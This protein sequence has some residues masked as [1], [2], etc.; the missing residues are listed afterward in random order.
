[1]LPAHDLVV[2]HRNSEATQDLVIPFK[3][4]C[5]TTDEMLLS[6]VKKNATVDKNWLA[7]E[8]ENQLTAILCASGPSLADNVETI[9]QLQKDGGCTVFAMNGASK[10]LNDHGITPF[11]QVIV[12]ARPQTA[13]LVDVKAWKHL[14]AS[15][16]DPKCFELAPDATIWHQEIGQI[17]DAL[18]EYGK[19][20]ALIGGG[21]SVGIS[22]MCI[23][24]T[25][26]YR[27]IK[28]F[29]YDSSHRENESHAFRQAMNDSEPLTTIRSNGKTYLCSFTMKQQAHKF[30][31]VANAL[32]AE[33]CSIDVIGDGLLPSIWNGPKMSE[34][35]K[36]EQMWEI[37]GYR[38]V[39]PGE[40]IAQTF[41]D[42]VKPEP[43][44]RIGDF[45]CG[46]GRGSLAISKLIDCDL[47]LMDFTENSRDEKAR[48][49]RFI[50]VDLTN[51]I[52][53]IVRH[54][55]C[56]DVMEH[57]APEDV[58]VVI[59]NILAACKDCFFQIST[60]PDMMGA[61][62]G[63]QLHLTVEPHAWWKE[64]LSKHGEVL[65][66]KEE[67]IASLFYVRSK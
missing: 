29:G 66:E 26:G 53:A 17:T 61:E 18:P 44:S 14:F 57:I 30:Q 34:Q 47:T 24:Y 49:F 50:K 3:L 48:G 12:D 7:I 52:P 39:S 46:T 4:V 42:V 5:N 15:Q 65:W 62:I 11:Y 32:I 28:C 45:G 63:Q 13:E 60:I 20:Y 40:L 59:K 38:H 58:H 55:Y 6:N 25:L 23:A 54:G 33:G 43:H 2:R 36:Y 41:I 9:R 67:D 21:T 27:K 22:A 1:M 19:Y 64:Q 8:P 56:C 37:D 16:V 51:E 31:E 35:E 10:F